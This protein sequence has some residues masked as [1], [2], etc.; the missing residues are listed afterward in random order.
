MSFQGCFLSTRGGGSQSVLV[1]RTMRHLKWFGEDWEGYEPPYSEQLVSWYKL[2][3]GSGAVVK[4]WAD[5]TDPAQKWPNLDI[6]GDPVY[7]WD[8]FKGF[9]SCGSLTNKRYCNWSNAAST[10]T[11]TGTDSWGIFFRIEGKNDTYPSFF[12]GRTITTGSMAPD[13]FDTQGAIYGSGLDYSLGMGWLGGTNASTG[14]YKLYYNDQI[15]RWLFYFI[16]EVD[17]GGTFRPK[18][19]VVYDDG[20]LLDTSGDEGWYSTA[21]A[22]KWV[23]LFMTYNITWGWDMY[24]Y[25]QLSDA[26]FWR[27]KKLVLSDWADIYDNLRG[28]YGMAARSGW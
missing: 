26:M 11:L 15:S 12:S 17:V 13:S 23:R 22:L 27:N 10:C 1:S 24:I 21:R 2:N 14:R 4:N 25:G 5:P 7:F 9:G 18:M 8:H 20:T 3:D 28:R 6:I 16:Y 19:G